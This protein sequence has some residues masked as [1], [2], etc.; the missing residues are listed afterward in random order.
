[1]P[2]DFEDDDIETQVLRLRAAIKVMND[3][4]YDLKQ[5]VDGVT[6]EMMEHQRASH[7][8]E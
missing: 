3:Q 2:T 7:N 8:S 1:M 5:L 4:L 6:I